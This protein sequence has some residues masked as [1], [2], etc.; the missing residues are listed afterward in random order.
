MLYAITAEQLTDFIEDTD[1]PAGIRIFVDKSAI[2][3][4]VSCRAGTVGS[5]SYFFPLLSDDAYT[6]LGIIGSCSNST[7]K[8]RAFVFTDTFLEKAQYDNRKMDNAFSMLIDTEIDLS[9]DLTAVTDQN[10]I[11]LLSTYQVPSV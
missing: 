1:L 3:D 9:A 11:T 4:F 5:Q 7:S 10:I 8:N 2:G 6:K